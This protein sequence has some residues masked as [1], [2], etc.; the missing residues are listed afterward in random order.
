LQT[1]SDR[2]SDHYVFIDGLRRLW[3]VFCCQ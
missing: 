1:T 2:L 3:L